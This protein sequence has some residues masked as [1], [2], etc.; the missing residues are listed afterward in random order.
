[1]TSAKLS[2]P[3][4]SG[5]PIQA[6]EQVYAEWLATLKQRIQEARLRPRT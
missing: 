4:G 2:R 5:T 6:T 1:M 3:I